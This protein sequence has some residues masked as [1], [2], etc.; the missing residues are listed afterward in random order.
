MTHTC[1]VYDVIPFRVRCDMESIFFKKN[2]HT[3]TRSFFLSVQPISDVI[4]WICENPLVFIKLAMGLCCDDVSTK[5][6]LK[7]IYYHIDL[8]RLLCLIY[9]FSNMHIHIWYAYIL[10]ALCDWSSPPVRPSTVLMQ[11]HGAMKLSTYFMVK[12]IFALYY[13]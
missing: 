7:N 4:L 10:S 2:T 9:L 13:V 1:D 11:H 12:P 3:L 5:V 8:S 6:F